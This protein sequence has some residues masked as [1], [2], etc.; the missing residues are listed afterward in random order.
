MSEINTNPIIPTPI[1][2]TIV[3][4]T[5]MFSA[6]P[7]NHTVGMAEVVLNDALV[8]RGLRIMN[9]MNG[10]FVA[11]P[12]DPFYRGDDFRSLVVPMQRAVR[13][14]IENAVLTAYQQK[15]EEKEQK[16]EVK[17]NSVEDVMAKNNLEPKDIKKHFVKGGVEVYYPYIGDDGKPHL[18]KVKFMK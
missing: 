17:Y 2:P 11:Y 9:G 15:L 4:I 18:G 5:D 8:I 1:I 3:R 10:L 6:N 13:D 14:T 16:M 7:T 12:N